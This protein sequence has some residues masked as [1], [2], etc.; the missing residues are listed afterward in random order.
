[1][2][3]INGSSRT[4]WPPLRMSYA[5][6]R[7]ENVA[8]PEKAPDTAVRE[9]KLARALDERLSSTLNQIRSQVQ[10]AAPAAPSYQ[11]QSNAQGVNPPEAGRRLDILA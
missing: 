8:R 11:A 2:T 9:Q 3:R 7:T 4:G 6:G 10:V 1:M 5:D